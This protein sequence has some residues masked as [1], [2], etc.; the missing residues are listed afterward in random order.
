CLMAKGFARMYE[1]AAIYLAIAGFFV[2]SNWRRGLPIIILTTMIQDPLRKLAPQQPVVFSL[3]A[4]AVAVITLIAS[5]RSPHPRVSRAPLSRRSSVLYAAIILMAIIALQ[6][7]NGLVSH[8]SVGAVALG[9]LTYIGPLPSILLGRHLASTSG[10][11]AVVGFI[12]VYLALAIPAVST[13]AIQ[14]MGFDWPI[15]GDVGQGIQI[16]DIILNGAPVGAFSGILRSSEIAAWHIGACCCFLTMLFTS[17]KVNGMSLLLCAICIMALLALGILTGRRKLV[18]QVSVFLVV[19]IFL[20]AFIGKVGPRLWIA[21]GF[22]IVGISAAATSLENLFV[23]DVVYRQFL[24]RGQ[25]GFYDAGDRFRQLGLGPLIWAYDR[26]GPLGAGVGAAT[27]GAQNYGV[28]AAMVAV[29]EGGLGKLAG[30]LG[31]PG[32]AAAAWLMILLANHVRKTTAHVAQYSATSGRLRCGM[33]AFLFA[34]VSTFSV[35]TQVFNDLFV[36]TT[37]GLFIGTLVAER[38]IRDVEDERR[39]PVAVLSRAMV[40]G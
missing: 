8:G 30:E 2:L 23:T 18:I 10:E 29:G 36:L 27:S 5:L 12:R 24:A 22:V 35:A 31:W 15:L 21:V 1:V 20:I 34:N 26:F 19:Y 9:I 37:L 11:R 7:V 3:M 17:R 14:Y 4:G 32:L 6:S 28:N 13:V 38:E 39:R 33:A 16:Y 25:T 40:R